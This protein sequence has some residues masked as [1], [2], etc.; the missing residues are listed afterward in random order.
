ME[1]EG[2]ADGGGTGSG[3]MRDERSHQQGTFVELFFDLVVVF[4]LNTVVATGAAAMKDDAIEVRWYGF[5][6]GIL[7]ILPLLW[8]WSTTAYVTTRFDPRRTP[9]RMLVL[10]TSL[11]V[12]FLG[13]AA[14]TAFDGGALIFVGVYLALQAGRPLALYWLLRRHPIR[15]LY[16]RTLVWS[17]V[18]AVPWL[19]GGFIHAGLSRA[20]V[21]LVAI[22]IDFGGARFGWPVPR[23]GRGRI[24]AWAV[25]PEYLA[26][27]YRQLMMI[28]LGES[29]LAVGIA[30]TDEDGL[31]SLTRTTGL[32]VGFVTT[33]LLWRIYF[34]KA[35]E[36]FG[37]AV[38]SAKDPGRL[39]LVAQT[40]HV[41]MI[42][43]I[44]ATAAGH[45][46]L[47]THPTGP[48]YPLWTGVI[49]TGPAIYLAGRLVLEWLVF[50]RLSRPR[51]LAIAALLAFT[52]PLA[53]VPPLA[54][55]S[56]VPV[57]LL[58]IAVADTRRAARSPGE[59]PTPP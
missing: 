4:A 42:L 20:L 31:R 30:Y 16:L 23:L 22:S 51:L 58:M 3:L 26:D 56:V 37:V 55:A 59:T 10:V 5:I 9:T 33:V 45:E 17:G 50:S 19:L 41:V 39:G 7:L 13:A 1:K 28:A 14:P 44:A 27:R 35:G 36:L 32:A 25:A 15:R 21:W 12:L 48:R 29:I 6:H 24:T 54:A 57:V 40:A 53:L 49:L 8:V 47:Q 11:G 52:V 2:S 18:S 34:Y 46:L 38:G 43:G